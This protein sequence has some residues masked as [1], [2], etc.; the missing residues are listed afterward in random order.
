V[1]PAEIAEAIAERHPDAAVARGEVSVVVDPS[2]LIPTL[3]ALRDDPVLRLDFLSN[4]AATDRPGR[5]PRFWLS[6]DLYS[7]ANHH[8]LR[9]KV[10]LTE[11]DPHVPSVVELHPGANWH[12]REN[13]DFYGIVFDGHPNLT[14]I[15]MPEDW[16]GFPLR[17][18]E[19]LGG[20]NTR[21]RGAFIPPVD[22][23][24]P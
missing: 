12:E 15:L 13:F 18:D 22:Q 16:D 23:R 20:V 5:S 8:R 17:K 19:E 24:T 10:G 4:I 9:V 2:E 21:Y 3:A 14:R 6:Y 11:G 7:I 1:T